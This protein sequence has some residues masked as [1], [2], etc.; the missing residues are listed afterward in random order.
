MSGG[1]AGF[2]SGV[3]GSADL[4]CGGLVAQQ[5]CKWRMAGVAR[6]GGNGRESVRAAKGNALAG[7][8]RWQKGVARWRVMAG[9]G[10]GVRW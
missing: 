6:K 4:A 7:D 3:G 10:V 8:G 2:I 1:G 5:G 9:G